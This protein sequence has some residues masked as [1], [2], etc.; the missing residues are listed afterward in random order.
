MILNVRVDHRLLHGQV[1]FSWTNHLRAN[2]ILIANDDVPH[3]EIRKSAMRLAR[4][5]GV[6]LIMKPID[7]C[8]KAINTG[9]TDKYKMFVIVESV[10]DAYRLIK[11]T[12]NIIN[13]L[14]LG[15]TKATQETVNV[16]K[17]VNLTK[18][19]FILLDELAKQNVKI[20][21][22]QVPADKKINYSD[23]KR[24]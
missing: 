9:L 18:D 20:Y 1:A 2:C 8:I 21:I 17:A 23:V 14:T 19:E 13:E 24:R 16:S 11:G 5:Q 3:D 7:E 15:G 6:K 22:Q 10:E 4:P 12:K